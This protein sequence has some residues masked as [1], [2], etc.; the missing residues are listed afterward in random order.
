M[1]VNG[2]KDTLTGDGQSTV[3]VI[4]GPVRLSLS[5]NFGAGTA[6]FQTKDPEGVWIDVSTGLT[7]AVDTNFDFPKNAQNE[8][9]VDLSGSTSPS[10]AVWLQ[11]LL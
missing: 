6:K 2:V 9:R 4:N 1:P 3:L 11:G 5:G 10:L 7:A 8:C